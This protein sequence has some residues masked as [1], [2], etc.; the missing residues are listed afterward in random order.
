MLDIEED[1][2]D[3]LVYV[4]DE[5]LSEFTE[6]VNTEIQNSILTM[7]EDAVS[8]TH[9]TSRTRKTSKTSQTNTTTTITPPK[10]VGELEYEIDTQLK[11]I[12]AVFHG[13]FAN[14]KGMNSFCGEVLNLSKAALEDCKKAIS[15]KASDMDQATK[16][17]TIE[18]YNRVITFC[19]KLEPQVQA[20]TVE[21]DTFQN[22]FQGFLSC[23][24]KH[25]ETT[26]H[27][28]TKSPFAGLSEKE[29]L[30]RKKLELR[31][32]KNIESSRR[33]RDRKNARLAAL[34]YNNEKLRTDVERMKIKVTDVVKERDEL[35][36][37]VKNNR[38]FH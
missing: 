29:E 6:F 11:N 2:I 8:Q 13:L 3:L 9:K 27:E 7:E 19:E 38:T 21:I 14:L 1:Y 36:M 28:Q 18:E 17:E 4:P 35:L 33:S 22:K 26:Q 25:M 15:T 20:Y 16:D 24:T 31:R 12:P 37:D 5:R 10:T 23:V 34:E 32:Q 30:K